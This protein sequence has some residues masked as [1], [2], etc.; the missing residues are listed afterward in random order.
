VK[1]DGN[2]E[3]DAVYADVERPMQRLLNYE[4]L[5]PPPREQAENVWTN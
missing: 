5:L 1:I 3:P 2:R 4:P